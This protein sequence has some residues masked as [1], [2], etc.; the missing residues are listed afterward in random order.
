MS[1][2]DHRASLASPVLAAV[3]TRNRRQSFAA[4]DAPDANYRELVGR[5]NAELYDLRG[6]GESRTA[7]DPDD[8]TAGQ[9]L[10]AALRENHASNG[11]VYPSVRYPRGRAVAAFWPDVVGILVQARHLCYR[12]DGRRVD[13]WLVYGEENWRL[14][15]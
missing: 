8:Y 7:L 10:A 6:E 1:I 5:I 11:V 12:W 15:A 9:A 3:S 14:L 13:A 2:S 4:T